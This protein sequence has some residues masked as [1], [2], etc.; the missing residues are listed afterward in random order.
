MMTK[1]HSSQ[2][3]CLA[4]SLPLTLSHLPALFLCHSV[5]CWLTQGLGQTGVCQ[6]QEE[7]RLSRLSPKLAPQRTCVCV[8]AGVCGPLITKAITTKALSVQQCRGGVRGATGGCLWQCDV[9]DRVVI[10][11]VR[12]VACSGLAW[13]GL[14]LKR[15]QIWLPPSPPPHLRTYVYIIIFQWKLFLLN[16]CAVK[17]HVQ[18]K[19]QKMKLGNKSSDFMEQLRAR[20]Q[21]NIEI[22]SWELFKEI[23]IQ[24]I[25]CI[26]KNYV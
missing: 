21:W 24:Y 17:I 15:G 3:C 12:Q 9:I 14:A 4:L 7:R 26:Y 11:S 8:C 10:V 20:Q 5:R 13:P 25:Q 1:N 19:P 22:E 2:A 16:R 6:L 18:K 23:D